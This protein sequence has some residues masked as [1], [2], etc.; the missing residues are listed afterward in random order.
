MRSNSRLINAKI[1]TINPTIKK[2]SG[3]SLVNS[4]IKRGKTRDK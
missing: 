2:D 4:C 1:Q 3:P